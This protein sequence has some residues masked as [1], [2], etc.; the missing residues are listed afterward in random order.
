MVDCLLIVMVNV[1]KLIAFDETVLASPFAVQE[2]TFKDTVPANPFAVQETTFK[3]AVP[4]SRK[5]RPIERKP[6][7][8][9]TVPSKENRL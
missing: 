8:E 1:L 5:D 6:L 4:V 7:I 2:T 3:D 9:Q